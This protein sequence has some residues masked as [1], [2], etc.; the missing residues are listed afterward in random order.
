MFAKIWAAS[1]IDLIAAGPLRIACEADLRPAVEVIDDALP[2]RNLVIGLRS[3]KSERTRLRIDD[4][5]TAGHPHARLGDVR[6]QGER[7]RHLRHNATIPA[8]LEEQLRPGLID[9]YLHPVVQGNIAESDAVPRRGARGDLK[10][11]TGCL[12]QAGRHRDAMLEM[13]MIPR[14]RAEFLPVKLNR[15][16]VFCLLLPKGQELQPLRSGQVEADM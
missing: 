13:M 10:E 15:P 16:G 9:E 14:Q 4:C 1:A 6:R 7:R 2:D 3:D 11:I 8:L 12:Q 5:E